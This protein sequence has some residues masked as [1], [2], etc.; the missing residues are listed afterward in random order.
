MWHRNHTELN[1]LISVSCSLNVCLRNV[2]F[3]K[4]HEACYSLAI[5]S[6]INVTIVLIV[7]NESMLHVSE[8]SYDVV[9]RPRCRG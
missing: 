1:R 7:N 3:N 4:F 9:F 5:S 8:E 6:D 2:L